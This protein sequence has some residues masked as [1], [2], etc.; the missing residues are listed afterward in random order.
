M[1]R[2]VYPVQSRRLFYMML[3][4]I[5]RSGRLDL[6]LRLGEALLL[7]LIAAGTHEGRLWTTTKASV[8][9]HESR[10][11][12][13]RFARLLE[14]RK[15]IVRERHGK[16]ISLRMSEQAAAENNPVYGAASNRALDRAWEFLRQIPEQ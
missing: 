13:D 15:F 12:I 9:L 7:L 5:V 10:Q 3:V 2:R 6:Q 4:D 16:S 8:Y 11:T 1:V 14:R